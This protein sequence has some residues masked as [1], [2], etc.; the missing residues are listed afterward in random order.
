M[1]A[2]SNGQNVTFDS[3]TNNNG[4][5]YI[6][7]VPY[8]QLRGYNDVA[9]IDLRQVGATGG[10]FASLASVLSY[11]SSEQTGGGIVILGSG[12]VK[13]GSGGGIVALGSGGI[14]ALGSG[15]VV[16]LGSGGTEALSSGGVVILGSGGVVILGSGGAS[17]NE[18]DYDTADSTVRPPVSP[19]ETP[20]S[21]PAGQQ[22]VVINWTAPA[23]GVVATYSIYRS[24]DGA[25]PILIG[26]VSGVDG[27]PP[28]TTFTDTNPD[29]ISTTV[30][31]TITTTLVPDPNGNQR[32]SP[33]SP[34]AVLKNNQ[35]IVLGSLPSSVLISSSPLTA[36]A[37]AETN[38]VANMQQVS[39]STSGNCSIGS[40]S[41]DPTTGISSASVTLNNTGSCTIT[42]SQSGSSSTTLPTLRPAHSRSCPR[43][44]TSNRK[45]S[46]FSNC[47][48]CSTAPP[49]H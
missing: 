33:P 40:Q 43:V 10:E 29:L 3:I 4:V 5:P 7:G 20:M 9:N 32:Q 38:G 2:W 28:A 25:T 41:I 26:S 31:Y 12:A 17:T 14:V 36:T 21:T 46:P 23:F 1:D 45:P 16:I 37:T 47:R 35:T 13:L 42:A 15:G 22:Q 44:P 34:P 39:F 48:M 6:D 18:L 49:S 11:N 30:V 24:S 8:T 27:N 19:S